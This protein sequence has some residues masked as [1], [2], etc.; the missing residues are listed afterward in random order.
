MTKRELIRYTA[1][2]APVALPY[3]AGRALNMHRFPGGAETAGF[4][5]KQL[6][7]HAPTGCRAGQTR[8]RSPARPAPTWSPTSLPR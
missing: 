7:E 2:I 1:Q 4:W 5:H 8:A 3:L 6:P